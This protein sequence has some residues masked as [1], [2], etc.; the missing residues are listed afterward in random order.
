[1]NQQQNANGEAARPHHFEWVVAEEGNADEGTFGNLL[2]R[3]ARNEK[4]ICRKKS[5]PN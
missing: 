3:M 1:M 2:P 5:P 4:R